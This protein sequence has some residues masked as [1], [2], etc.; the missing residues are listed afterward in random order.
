MDNDFIHLS[1][2]DQIAHV[3]GKF[4]KDKAYVLLTLAPAKLQGR[5][6]YET[7]PGGTT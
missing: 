4:W 1:K 2:Q 5:L 6:V 7:N 3:A